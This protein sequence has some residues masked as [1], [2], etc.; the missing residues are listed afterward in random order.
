MNG[1]G[2]P[3]PVAPTPSG[4]GPV[5]LMIIAPAQSADALYTA[6]AADGRFTIVAT[7]SSADDARGKLALR[8]EAVIADVMAFTG[9]DQFAQTLGAYDG[10]CFALGPSSLPYG[11]QEAVRAVRCVADLALGDPNLVTLAG[12]IYDA[13]TARRTGTAAAAPGTVGGG[14]ASAPRA[15]MTGWRAIAVWGAQGGIGKST[16]AEALALE[17]A[18]RSLPTLLI[19]LG[20]P[21]SVPLRLKLKASPNIMHWLASPTLDGLKRAIQK[22]GNL[23]VLTG[24]PDLVSLGEYLPH[25]FDGDASLVN[26]ANTAAFAGYGVVVFDVSSQELAAAALSASNTL[27]LMLRPSLDGVQSALEAVKAVNDVLSGKH[28]IPPASR[29]LVVNRVRSSTMTPEEAVK[30]AMSIRPDFPPLT[31]HVPDDP[32]IEEADIRQEPAYF[33]SDVLRRAARTVGDRL[34]ASLPP[35]ATAPAK[36]GKV[37]RLGPFKVR[38][39]G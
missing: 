9:P 8:P 22:R 30:A 23:D 13:A 14:I 31:A 12:R 29:F 15:S 2:I 28:K 35:S 6:F 24:F 27:I 38:V 7:A 39:G 18:S 3:E 37:K 21:D 26:L 1:W 19:G 34:F 36:V 4:E 17:A 20:A 25:A 5:A 32:S 11:A 10:I 16:F 33:R